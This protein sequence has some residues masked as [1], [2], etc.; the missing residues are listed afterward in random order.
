MSF[1]IHEISNLHVFVGHLVCVSIDY[2]CCEVRYGHR[3][4]NMGYGLVSIVPS[5]IS[6]RGL[7]TQFNKPLYRRYNLRPQCIPTIHSN[8]PK[9]KTSL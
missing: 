3:Y 1:G 4:F 5:E 7:W 2:L 8:L 6:D 9:R